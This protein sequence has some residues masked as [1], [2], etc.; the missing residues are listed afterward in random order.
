MPEKSD[1]KC[2]HDQKFTSIYYLHD[3]KGGLKDNQ[4]KENIF[5]INFSKDIWYVQ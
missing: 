1:L 4:W 3:L 2:P 5:S